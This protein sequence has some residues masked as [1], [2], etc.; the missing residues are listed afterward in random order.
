MDPIPLDRNWQLFIDDY[1][2]ARSTG[3]SRVVHH[4]RAMGVVIPADK[5]WETSAVSGTYVT[6]RD[7][8][9]FAAYYRAIWWDLDSA[10]QINHR[11]YRQDRAHHKF[12]GMAYAT[13]EDGVYW[14][15]PNLG[16]VEGPAES[17]WVKY[18]PFPTPRGTSKENN[19]GVP[20][21][22]VADLGQYG[23]VSD[24]AKR[25]ALRLAPDP[26]KPADVG[27]GWRHAP[28][29]Y[30]GQEIPD[31][32]NDPHWREKLVDSGSTFDPRRC[33]VHFWDDVDQK[34]VSMEQGV[35]GH[36]LPSREVARFASKDLIH[37]TSESVLYP[38][39]ADAHERHCYDE[40]HALVPFCAEGVVFG[41]LDWFH[42]DR[43]HPEGGPKLTDPSQPVGHVDY[44]PLCRKAT[45][46]TRITISRDGGK[47]W[48]RTSSRE[49][50]IPH[51]TEEDSYDR[52]LLGARPPVRVGDED[53]FYVGAINGDHLGVRNNAAQS[54]YYHDRMRVS[55]T[56]LYIQKH[57]RYVS[58]AA[59]NYREVLITKPLT[60]GGDTLRL[61][62]DA[63]RGEVRV[64][65]A[66]AAPVMTYGNTPS[67][68][69]YL[70][71]SESRQLNHLLPG[72][73]FDDCQPIHANSIEHTVQFGERSSLQ[74]LRGKPVVL[75][76]Q[77]ANADL[78]GFRTAD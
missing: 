25:Y 4:P 9:S 39:A 76:F 56:A 63:S 26:S 50:W 42:S 32:L 3:C 71:W 20:F 48:D 61:N 37:W 69:P 52:A 55:Q 62:V 22:I 12:T 66:L 49:A 67:T 44:W 5:P 46:E 23:N 73:R 27:A 14:Q 57:N 15:K 54:S 35:V 6:R 7:D 31:F 40:A 77:V 21:V 65:I 78:Y 8:G 72:F 13:S 24:P 59:R 70:L 18:A 17:D 36:W 68:A 51:G 53:W 64:G 2:V 38:D 45:A 1:V 33:M 43:T 11:E 47:T 28:R 41:L 10:N 74:S 16:L 58:L 29:G 75:L 19:L 30:F 60:L 34:W